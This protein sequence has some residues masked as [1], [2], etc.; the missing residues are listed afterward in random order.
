M[1]R[2]GT[3]PRTPARST[4]TRSCTASSS[5]SWSERSR[6]PRPSRARSSARRSRNAVLLHR[7]LLVAELELERLRAGVDRGRRIEDRL[8][9][10]HEVSRP[11]GG[12]SGERR[13]R[14]RGARHR[15]RS[16]TPTRPSPPP[17]PTTIRRRSPAPQ[18]PDG[19]RGVACA[20]G[21]HRRDGCRDPGTGDRTVH[22]G[23][24]RI[25]SHASGR[26]TPAPT[27][28][29][30]TAA[31]V[32]IARPATARKPAYIS[33]REA[34]GLRRSSTEPPAQNAGG[35]AVSTRAPIAGSSATSS[36]A[37]ASCVVTSSES[38]LRR[39]GSSRVTIGDVAV[40]LEPHAGVV[41]V[42]GPSI[43]RGDRMARWTSSPRPT[44][45]GSRPGSTT[46]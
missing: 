10:L 14:C 11:V 6:H 31:T 18:P 44:S 30:L 22:F 12:A 3:G 42:H 9:P 25:T 29:P 4:T 28:G 35:V 32:G 13:P 17:R 43:V 26:L 23:D 27:T 33:R 24:A 2:S 38:A 20:T 36:T 40:T 39:A 7:P 46:R 16:A 5:T 8:H 1:S 34:R 19:R 21:D 37:A 45:R 41:R 15:R